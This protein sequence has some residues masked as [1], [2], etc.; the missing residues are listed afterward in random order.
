MYTNCKTG[1]LS[2]FVLWDQ[3]VVYFI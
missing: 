2:T 1:Y 3:N